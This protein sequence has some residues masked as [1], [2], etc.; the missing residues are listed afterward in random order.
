[1]RHSAYNLVTEL[2]DGS[3][4]L[5][6]LLSRAV[7]AA[8]R[9]QLELL[10]SL[11]GDV[12]IQSLN[13]DERSF[14]TALVENLF[15]L[16]DDF[17]EL[18][19]IRQMHQRERAGREV[20][21]LVIAPTMQC[22]MSCHYCF[23]NRTGKSICQ[24]VQDRLVESTR[25]GLEAYE[26]LHV[27]WFGGE[28]LLD[29]VVIEALS[30]RF[31]E[32]AQAQ[33]KAY[34]AEVI[35][36]GYLLTADVARR[37]A[38]VHVR[39]AQVTFEGMRPFHDK[40]RFLPAHE[41]SF[42]QLVANI[43]TA[44]DFLDINV[45]VHVAPYNLHS[46]HEL[47]EYLGAN[48]SQHITRLYFSPLF[49][50][51]AEGKLAQYLV[52]RRKFL[53]AKDFAGA[54][55]ELVAKAKTYGLATGDPLKA[56]YGLCLAMLEGTEVVGPTGAVTKC[57]LDIN[58]AS[59]AHSDLATGRKEPELEAAWTDYNFAHDADCRTCKFLPV[60]MGG[61]P[62][63]RMHKADKQVVCTPLK[64]NFHQRMRMEYQLST[65]ADV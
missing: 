18:A 8:D 11:R 26:S 2:G 25:L 10:A 32:L 34:S 46:V 6:N 61:C 47:L 15:V 33:G 56:S 51:Q 22:N 12:D 19:H 40:V 16:P 27:Q 4:L 37:L 20:K 31:F 29:V 30:A 41:P 53:G 7:L 17:D 3:V 52:D 43:R 13:D 54:Q 48:L 24:A 39:E 21:N 60:C 45:R 28:P 44:S 58:V 35:T 36:N 49:N 55:V 62:S 50:Y 5:T 64:Y 59:K 42:D 38:A 1:V 65:Q 63:Q 23:E 14:V 57:Y 9:S